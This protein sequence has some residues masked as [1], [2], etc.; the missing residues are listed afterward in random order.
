MVYWQFRYANRHHTTVY[1]NE[2]TWGG[3]MYI[4]NSGTLTVT[5]A[6]VYDNEATDDGGGMYIGNS[7]T[8]TVTN[9]TVYDNEATDDG[10]GLALWT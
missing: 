2:A 5:N 8:L 1:D 7:G 4:G 9:A 6:T 10:G 3:G